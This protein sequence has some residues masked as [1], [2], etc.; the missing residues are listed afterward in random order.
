MKNYI[1]A[2]QFSDATTHQNFAKKLRAQFNNNHHAVHHNIDFM[3]I[4]GRK[5]PGVEAQV[6]D[7]FNGMRWDD[8][9]FVALIF[10]DRHEE[11]QQVRVML[12]GHDSNFESHLGSDI[13][14]SEYNRLVNDLLGAV[15]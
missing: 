3:T 8:K 6:K 9:D 10:A 4:R 11:D 1:V 13:K 14:T 12:L 15:A 5:E 2:Y 7:L